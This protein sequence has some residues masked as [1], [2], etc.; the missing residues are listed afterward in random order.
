MTILKA[1][2][3]TVPS[4]CLQATLVTTISLLVAATASSSALAAPYKYEK[5]Q[6]EEL[7]STL[8]PQTFAYPSG[9][10][11]DAA[12]DLFVA[13]PLG[14]AGQ[15]VIDKFNDENVLQAQLGAPAL[16]GESAE[17]VAVNDETGHVYVSG[18]NGGELTVLNAAGEELSRWSGANTPSK[19]FSNRVIVAVD[20]SSGSSKGDVY[21]LT[22]GFGGEINVFEPQNGDKEEGKI[23]RT[24]EPPVPFEFEGD[25]ESLTV[26]ATTGQVYVVDASHQSSQKIVDRFSAEGAFEQQI[27]GPSSSE[28]FN[29]PIAVAVDSA[30]GDVYVIDHKFHD[31]V[32]E[33]GPAG[34]FLNQI[35]GTGLNEPFGGLNGIAVQRTGAH[36]GE[37]YVTDRSTKVVDVFA[38]QVPAAPKIESEGVSQLFSDSASLDAAI[39]PEGA[40]TEYR[41]EYG[42]CSGAGGIESC[43]SSPYTQSVPV[44]DA[45]LGFED[46]TTHSVS[47]VS[48]TGLT[49]GANYHFR[50]VA[51]N[52]VGSKVNTV[53]GEERTFTT[54]AL[55]GTSELPD[56]RVWELVSP[57]EK[58]GALIT[59][60]S[61][62]GIVEAAADG[63]AITYLTSEPTELALSG[64]ANSVNVLST[65]AAGGWSS[66][67]LVIAHATPTGAGDAAAPEYRFFAEDLSSAVVQPLGEFDPEVSPEASEQT[68]YVRTL[69]SCTES[70][71][72]PLVTG[73]AGFA[74][75]PSGTKFGE[76][77]PCEQQPA[78]AE[79]LEC[80]PTFWDATP[81]ARH[82]VLSSAAPL[83]LGA[84]SNELYE[85]TEG[86]LSQISL[87]PAN[88][89]GEELPAPS[90]PSAHFES[91]PLLGAGFGLS[92]EARG[93]AMRAISEDG[94][95]VYWESESVLYLRDLVKHQTLQ[96]D[97]AEPE[98]LA[99][100]KCASGG[101]R[102]QIAS[103]DGSRVYFTDEHR[104]TRDA[105]ANSGEPDLYECQIVEAAGELACELTDLTPLT[106]GKSVDVQG[107]VLG[108]SEDGSTVYFV[109][110]GALAGTGAERGT[111]GPNAAQRTCNLYVLHPGSPAKLVAVLSGSDGTVW[112]PKFIRPERVSPDGSW[113]TFMSSRSLTDYDNRDAV[114]GQPDAEVYLYD[115]AAN[116]LT[117]ASCDP[118]GARPTGVEYTQL[119]SGASEVLPGVQGEW[120]GTGWVSALLP[121]ATSLTT[122]AESAYQSRYLSDS[123]RLFFNSDDALVPQDVNGT[124]DVYEFEPS[125]VGGCSTSSPQ[126]AERSGGCVGLISSGTSP[127]E[128]SFLD[129][130]ESGNNVFFLTSEQ[131]TSGDVD[132]LRDVYD[133][134]EC[135]AASPCTPMAAATPPA[136]VTEASCKA[137]P[138]PQ[139]AIFGAPASATFSG[140]GNLTPPVVVK[141][142]AKPLTRAQKLTKRTACE[143]AA[144]KQFGAVK[145]AKVRKKK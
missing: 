27:T 124:G 58:Q 108:A 83:I 17:S 122:E 47:P 75:V 7:S 4:R 141:P 11:F 121:R 117:C 131:L 1:L 134:H 57:P 13:D 128:S 140:A 30:S 142:K 130:S 137:A 43:A 132:S 106:A 89:N 118:S 94:S 14:N 78:V 71:L 100:G 26:D 120:E 77:Q 116:R 135:S 109:A 133:A 45:S 107:D 144:R 86:A 50:V 72:R 93:A 79:T 52:K 126:F 38:E 95:H 60:I 49:A 81:D 35:T 143:K 10:T 91:Q 8:A 33:F 51:H 36:A 24:L 103:T 12:G 63:S 19:A 42:Q 68:P 20:N 18:P 88:G 70:C 127:E 31:A 139:P 104:L 6:S 119:L 114:S 34:E 41:F 98:C 112:N 53:E 29:E 82:A 138:S 145:K 55:A 28:A 9:L 59:K 3:L 15:G 115:A 73:R 69:G 21:V 67:D 76:D 54:Q 84:G 85:W 25:G 80:G 92:R 65:R 101:G 37:V 44:P 61:N 46:F 96:I 40:A 90:S 23:V 87:L 129:A 32:D 62:D 74:N 39:N 123:G 5:A 56:G 2:R 110:D 16:T 113:L 111:C 136:C 48:V 102:F 22:T 99:E 125:G 97:A 66:H 105:G 64:Y